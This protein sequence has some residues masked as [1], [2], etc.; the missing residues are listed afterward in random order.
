M[1]GDYIFLPARSAWANLLQTGAKEAL[2]LPAQRDQGGKG[3][4]SEVG[5]K[6]S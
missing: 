3:N 5:D 1:H 6:W 4:V 2:G